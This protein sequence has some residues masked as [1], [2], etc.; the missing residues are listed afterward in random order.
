MPGPLSAAHTVTKLPAHDLERARA[1]S[2]GTPSGTS[3]QMAFEVD[4]LEA[5]PAVPRGSTGGQHGH[6]QR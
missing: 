3:T 2:A 1:F 6:A 5:T 4:D